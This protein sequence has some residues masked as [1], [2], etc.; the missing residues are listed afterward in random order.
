MAT[1]HS[2]SYTTGGT[3]PQGAR[4]DVEQHVD[5]ELFK[6]LLCGEVCYVLASPQM[7][8]NALLV[9]TAQRLREAGATVAVLDLTAAGRNLTPERWY[10]GLLMSLGRQLDLEDA[11]EDFWLDHQR[12]APFQRFMGAI[13][14][15][16]LGV[17]GANASAAERLV[18]FIDEI[19]AVRSLPFSADEL[20]AGIRECYNRR[21]QDPAFQRLTFCLLG[22]ASPGDLMR[23]T[24]TTPFNIG[25][26]I[27]MRD[28][29]DADAP[30][31]A[32]GRGGGSGVGRLP[33]DV[34][35]GPNALLHRLLH[36]IGCHPYLTASPPRDGKRRVGHRTC[37]QS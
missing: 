19:D 25:R 12:L 36:W 22:A 35:P 26:R 29:T 34:K 7:G 5:E 1:D 15:V 24:R 13:H 23:D 16:A 18:I 20:F 10:D 2:A 4:S 31:S 17:Q 14:A 30:P 37:G 9:G 33:S 32:E 21:T 11:M 6:S 27:E 3:L 28:S 8:K